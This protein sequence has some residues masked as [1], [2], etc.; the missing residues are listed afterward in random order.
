MK[1]KTFFVFAIFHLVFICQLFAQSDTAMIYMQEDAGVEQ[2]AMKKEDASF[3]RVLLSPAND[4]SLYRVRDYYLSG[5]LK[6]SGE[7]LS[8]TWEKKLHGTCI[9]YFENGHKKSI[10][11]YE[12]GNLTGDVVIYFPNGRVNTIKNTG[13][14]R[15]ISNDIMPVW[16]YKECLD[17]LGNAL[18]ENGEGKWIENYDSDEPT[19][20]GNVK[21]GLQESEWHGRINDTLNYSCTF[22][23]GIIIKGESQSSAGNKYPFTKIQVLPEFPGGVAKFGAFLAKTI[24]YPADARDKRIQGRVIVT[25]IV[26]KDGTLTNIKV[27]R[28]LSPSLDNE[29]LNAMKKSPKWIPGTRYGVKDEVRYSVPVSFTL[30]GY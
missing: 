3:I 9:S 24:R 10:T 4:T 6:F 15:G 2:P 29:A 20:V 27:S 23:K 11:T 8:P 22:N 21:D 26:K 1:I 19:A 17:S 25:F 5:K 18:T 12:K 7:S 28:G 30:A 16:T 13:N 14:D